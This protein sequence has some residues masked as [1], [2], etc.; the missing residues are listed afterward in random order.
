MR[1]C[2]FG[3][4]C[5]YFLERKWG[6]I[7]FQLPHVFNRDF[8]LGVSFSLRVF[9]VATKKCVVQWIIMKFNCTYIIVIPPR[10]GTRYLRC[11]QWVKIVL[12]CIPRYVLLLQVAMALHL[13]NL[14]W[15]HRDITGF[16]AGCFFAWVNKNMHIWNR[17]R[18]SGIDKHILCVRD[19]ILSPRA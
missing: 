13:S 3:V 12:L 11:S 10:H 16:K 1:I 14:L 4:Y 8:D 15:C 18:V 6:K 9:Q 17:K 19:C 2:K 7:V 5:R